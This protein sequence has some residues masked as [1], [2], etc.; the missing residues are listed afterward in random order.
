[1]TQSPVDVNKAVQE[2]ERLLAKSNDLSPALEAAIKI[3]IV[4]VKLL[5]DRLGL[6]SS[7][8][9]KP[10][11]S[12]LNRIKKPRSKNANKP[13]GQDGHT[14][15][16]LEKVENPDD[17]IPINIDRR[18]L[19]A[20][21]YSECGYEC[22]QV[23]DIR[24]SRFVTEYRAQ[25]LES[26]NGKRFIA[27]FPPEA[28][29]ATQYGASIKANA[30]YMSMFQ[31]IPYERIQTHFSEIFN[32][33]ISAGSLYNFNENAYHRLEIFEALNKDQL[34]KS[35][36]LHVDE[37]GV[38]I[39]GKRHWLH[40]ASTAEWTFIAPHARRGKDAMDS[41]EILPR[42]TGLMIHD[43]W[44]PYYRFE[45]CLH[46]LCNAHHKRELT[47]AYEQDGQNWALEMENML[48]NI[49]EETKKAGGCLPENES[50]KWRRKYRALLK[51]ADAECPAPEVEL[52][53]PPKRG[54]IARSKSRN[55]LE[56]LRDYEGDVLRFMDNS[57]APYTNNQG[58][59]DLRMT[60]V[61]QKISGCFRS[62]K[63][64]EIYCRIRSYISTC[65]KHNV[66]VG[67]ALECLFE[68]RWPVFIQ[69]KLENFT[70]DAE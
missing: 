49:N 37:T 57:L 39:G 6:N 19:P 45:G 63:G 41:M 55:L 32:I 18:T 48:D 42:F 68:G 43:H 64:A 58:E 27:E 33:P 26:D 61:Q 69:K 62:M 65:R 12:D 51:K 66:G 59:R 14:G 15:S 16:N 17:I 23:F 13:G 1:M 40:N 24:I 54:R 7:N 29:C 20:G 67:E 70:P 2:V 35:G 8:S 10:P 60:K 25:V 5:T 4:V 53:T 38:N 11:S 22:R 47:R 56:R 44:K 50:K 36:A 9:S 34:R 52:I 30:V 46:V 28:A 21:N 3:L 31:L